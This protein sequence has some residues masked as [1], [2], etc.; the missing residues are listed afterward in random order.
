[1]KALTLMQASS[2]HQAA[3][4]LTS[5]TA[6]K[7]THVA[8]TRIALL[9]MTWDV[10]LACALKD[11]RET[12]STVGRT[13]ASVSSTVKLNTRVY[14]NRVVCSEHNHGQRASAGPTNTLWYN[15]IKWHPSFAWSVLSSV[16]SCIML[17]LKCRQ[18][19]YAC[20]SAGNISF[21][22]CFAPLLY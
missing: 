3:T 9:T 1:M 14:E 19:Y 18:M 5:M 15:S 21:C 22:F 7:W 11:I 13:K 8:T 17:K 12:G 6:G 2:L 4:G 16:T 20:A 10:T